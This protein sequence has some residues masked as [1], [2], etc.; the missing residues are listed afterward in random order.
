MCVSGSGFRPSRPKP[1][2]AKNSILIP[3]QSFA[4]F[5]LAFQQSEPYA[6]MELG[7]FAHPNLHHT[8]HR[9]NMSK[10]FLH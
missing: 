9:L 5:P 10:L 6:E 8:L 7:S 4:L 3:K 2:V 1:E